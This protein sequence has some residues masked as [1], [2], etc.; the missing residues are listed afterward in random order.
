MAKSN[1]QSS[2]TTKAT[3]KLD[4]LLQATGARTGASIDDLT[5]L[6]GW[7]PHSVRAALSRLRAR[8]YAIHPTQTKSGTRYRMRKAK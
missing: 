7:Q 1:T 8:G 3:S 5:A 4:H 6:T 2:D